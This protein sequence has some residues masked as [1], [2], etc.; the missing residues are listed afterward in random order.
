MEVLKITPLENYCLKRGIGLGKNFLHELRKLAC[1]DG[2][3]ERALNSGGVSYFPEGA[4]RRGRIF[5]IAETKDRLF[6]EFNI[7]FYLEDRI[8]DI[9][10]LT[11]DDRRLLHAGGVNFCY[12]GNSF[13]EAK[14]LIIKAIV[15]TTGV[16]YEQK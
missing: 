1:V 9:V 10:W 14:K 5:K 8:K 11:D 6:L 4:K 12:V 16:Q 2:I 3:E 7:T 15:K 13:S